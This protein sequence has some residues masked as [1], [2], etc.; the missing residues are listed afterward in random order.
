MSAILRHIVILRVIDG[1]KDY[2]YRLVGDAQAH[3]T[4]VQA[5]KEGEEAA[6]TIP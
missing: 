1:G 6:L 5:F 3:R 4:A 2:E